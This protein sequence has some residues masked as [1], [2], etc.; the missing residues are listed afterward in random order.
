MI[1][2]PH[3]RGCLQPQWPFRLNRQSLQADAL[4]LAFPGFADSTAAYELVRDGWA[5]SQTTGRPF[6]M[7]QMLYSQGLDAVG[8]AT[9]V[10]NSLTAAWTPL[11]K[12]QPCTLSVWGLEESGAT[13]EIIFG[14]YSSAFTKRVVIQTTGGAPQMQ[15]GSATGRIAHA[16][17]ATVNDGVFHHLCATYDGS[18]TAAGIKIYIDAVSVALT[19]DSDSDPGTWTENQLRSRVQG[20]SGFNKCWAD[21]RLY[22]RVLSPAEV[23]QLYDPRTRWDLYKRAA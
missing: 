12:T 5:V 20:G 17:S 2:G 14:T 22:K 9:F 11:T 3:F 15:I 6:S 10:V 16:T 23:W 13:S 21:A 18:D 8:S 1:R 19:I 4:L 7:K